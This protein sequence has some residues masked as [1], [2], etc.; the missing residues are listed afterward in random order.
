MS[1]SEEIR[2]DLVSS[3][4]AQE[5][6]E[7]IDQFDIECERTAKKK[8]LIEAVLQSSVRVYDIVENWSEVALKEF[9]EAIGMDSVGRKNALLKKLAIFLN[10]AE[11]AS[12]PPE[13]KKPELPPENVQELEELESVLNQQILLGK[14]NIGK[15][16]RGFCGACKKTHAKQWFELADQDVP[17]YICR[18]GIPTVVIKTGDQYENLSASAFVLKYKI[19]GAEKHD[20]QILL[21]EYIKSESPHDPDL[22]TQVASA[23]GIEN[24]DLKLFDLTSTQS[25]ASGAAPTFLAGKLDK[26]RQFAVKTAQAV[27]KSS[28][29]LDTDKGKPYKAALKLFVNSIP[30]GSLAE[31][32]ID[33][34]LV[35]GVVA[36]FKGKPEA[37]TVLKA[38]E[39]SDISS[40]FAHIIVTLSWTYKVDL[41]LHALYRTKDGRIGEIYHENHGSLRAF[42]FMKLDGDAGVGKT[43]G[44]NEENLTIKSFAE[45]EYVLI[46]VNIFQEKGMFSSVSS[47]WKK[48][49]FSHYDGKVIIQPDNGQDI[50][51]PLSSVE[52]GEWCVVAGIQNRGETLRILNVNAVT[53]KKPDLKQLKNLSG[54]IIL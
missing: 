48:E 19:S 42:P 8:Q 41:D 18:I 4:T 45:M 30:G 1:N 52:N 11:E 24:I 10:E 44:D 47:L 15:I 12:E 16:N 25:R 26:F 17:F 49:S 7:I 39:F 28:S 20:Y 22:K 34:G 43:G 27:E 36:R 32:A 38:K 35:G 40:K 6:R 29:F 50:E 13:E 51:I 3:L 5:L 53:A 2:T 14:V 46:A 33:S 9:C 23:G 21:Q 54:Q 31:F 37:P